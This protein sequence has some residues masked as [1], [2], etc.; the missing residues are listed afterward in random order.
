MTN[1]VDIRGIVPLL[2]Y[3]QRFIEDPARARLVVKSRQTGFTKFVLSL[4]P[5]LEGLKG[6][7]DWIIL[8]AGER[9]SGEVID[10]VRRHCQVVNIAAEFFSE[11][12][13]IPEGSF[14][15]LTV[16][17]PNGVRVI[18]L[19]ANPAT[20]RGYTGHVILDEFALHQRSREIWAALTGSITWGFKIIVCSTLRGIHNKFYELYDKKDNEKFWSKHHVDI[21]EAVADGLPANVEELK[22]II[23]DPAVWAEEFECI[24]QDEATTLLPHELISGCEASEL[25]LE[26]AQTGLPG[27][28]YLG[29]DIGRKHDLTVFWLLEKTGGVYWTRGI[30]ALRGVKFAK[31]REFL[32]GLLEMLPSLRRCCIDAT[33]IGAQ[34]AEE[35]RD[36]FGSRVEEVHFTTAVKEDLAV[37]ALRAFQDR[38]V[39]IPVDPDIRRSLNSIK[40]TTTS[41]G[42]VRFDAERN[43]H[44]HADHF[45]ALAL[46]L[47]GASQPSEPVRVMSVPRLTHNLFDGYGGF[48]LG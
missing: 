25:Q 27:D 9:Q 48:V 46:A 44:G 10:A 33:G 6:G 43:Q 23:D 1:A 20:A 8:S 2:P 30:Q 34:L 32:Y 17:L 40:K 22:G 45:W 37:T 47:H 36:A 18:G 38:S 11:D 7:A 14:K 4:I 15:Q 26:L 21:H 28:A 3:Q 5:V 41:S 29:V 31:Q 35:A 16:R 13:R 42:N 19:P 39:K 12:F 24:P